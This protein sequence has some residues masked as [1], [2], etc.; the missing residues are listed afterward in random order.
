MGKLGGSVNRVVRAQ[1]LLGAPA[2]SKRLDSSTLAK[3]DAHSNFRQGE[4]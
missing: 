2:L 4:Q 3:D 1:T